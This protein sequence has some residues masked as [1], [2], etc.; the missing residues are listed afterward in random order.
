MAFCS[1]CGKKLDDGTELCP[2]C[3]A[4]VTPE[5]QP[6]NAENQSAAASSQASQARASVEDTFRQLN[7]TSDT[8]S[9][10]DQMDINNNKVMAVLAYIG[11]LVLV[12]IFAAKDSKFARFH[13]N[14]GLIL[15]IASV[16]YN[17]VASVIRAILGAV[18]GV[19]GGIVGW[20]L[21]LLSLVFL[22]LAIIGIV[23][24]VNGKAKELP[25]IGKFKILTR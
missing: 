16:A 23:N 4:R 6:G 15:L 25:V 11:I 24:A 18:L 3:G 20:I 7:N 10:F 8:T 22:A 21:T 1:K 9:E 14:Q 2:E 12:P 13:A 17:I 5:G 19:V